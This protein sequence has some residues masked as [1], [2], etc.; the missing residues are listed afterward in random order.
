M[1]N[2]IFEK[3]QQLLELEQKYEKLQKDH[4]KA[5]KEKEY[6]YISYTKMIE[7]R[8]HWQ[9]LYGEA[10]DQ[11]QQLKGGAYVELEHEHKEAKRNI[12]ALKSDLKNLNKK[13]ENQ[14]TEIKN[15]SKALELEKKFR[16]DDLGRYCERKKQ[17][18]AQ[19]KKLQ[20]C[21][22][23]SGNGWLADFRFR[24]HMGR[25]PKEYKEDCHFCQGTGQDKL[26]SKRAES[27]QSNEPLK[28]SD[29]PIASCARCNDTGQIKETYTV[30]CPNCNGGD[31][32]KAASDIKLTGFPKVQ[33][34]K[35]VNGVPVDCEKCNGDG[36]IKL[37]EGNLT[38]NGEIAG[39]AVASYV[40]FD[41]NGT[42]KNSQFLNLPVGSIIEN[43]TLKNIFR[44]WKILHFIDRAR[45]DI[46]DIIRRELGIDLPN[47]NMLLLAKL[48]QIERP[49]KKY[50][51]ELKE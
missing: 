33:E 23:C 39:S 29:L 42:G 35:K 6:W 19:I 20:E 22:Y 18:E 16:R 43:S 40:C 51:I 8:D 11:I 41:C 49:L 48:E 10:D 38:I 24:C 36:K 26:W 14:K 46:I 2:I 44:N 17:M 47:D 50:G 27:Q 31:K 4:E 28:I 1:Q 32:I 37:G 3:I 13:I 25:A 45:A 7:D 21:R 15:L 5:L 9:Q 34:S 30:F 12:S